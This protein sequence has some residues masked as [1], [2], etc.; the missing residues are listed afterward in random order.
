VINFSRQICGQNSPPTLSALTMQIN[1]CRHWRG[2]HRRS[3]G[4]WWKLFV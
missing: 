3:V 4:L 2:K 1:W